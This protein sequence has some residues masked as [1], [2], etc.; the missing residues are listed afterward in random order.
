MIYVKVNEDSKVLLVHSNP[1][2]EKEG[3][4]KTKEE[5]EQEGF[6]F[7][8][9]KEIP[10]P[11]ER[12]GYTTIIYTDGR[13]FWFDYEKNEIPIEEKYLQEIQMMKEKHEQLKEE[14]LESDNKISSIG[15]INEQLE[16]DMKVVNA[17]ISET[18]NNLQGNLNDSA[19]LLM[20][21]MEKEMQIAD[22]EMQI[23]DSRKVL[24]EQKTKIAEQTQ[25]ITLQKEML[26]KQVEA[27]E[28]SKNDFELIK[29]EM[30]EA[31]NKLIFQKADLDNATALTAK[32]LE[33]SGNMLMELMNT[34]VEVFSVKE[35]INEANKKLVE[36]K[37]NL[38]QANEEMVTTKAELTNAKRELLMTQVDVANL[39]MMLL[40][41]GTSE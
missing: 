19:M 37:E 1:L 34:Q 40:E 16:S 7:E 36:T 11:T 9:L 5:L 14:K 24:E 29:E 30:F 3:L 31:Q 35:E 2:D 23:I 41:G 18:T 21:M 12:S 39:L 32:L 17:Q 20:M 4:G 25:D 26:Q 13:S 22:Q 38:L 6:F 8:F 28:K 27:I 10:R 15:S 33:D